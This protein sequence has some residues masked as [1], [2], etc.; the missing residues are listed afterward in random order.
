ML[1][2][3]IETS[4]P[5]GSIAVCRDEE[6]LAEVELEDAPRRHAQTLVSQIGDTFG[7]LSLKIADLDA[8]AVSIGPGSFTG[9]RVGVVCAKTLAYAIGCQLVAV[10]TLETIAANSPPD[11]VSVDVIADAQRGDL[12]VANYRRNANVAWDRDQ[13]PRI[14]RADEWFLALTERDVVSGPGLKVSQTAGTTVWRSL[15][16]SAW[17]P[18]ARKA[19]QIGARRTRL[20]LTADIATL[21]PFYVRRSAAEEK[22][23]RD[24][25][26]PAT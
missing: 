14:V 22:A 9:L 3:G 24:R 6:C 11:V 20:G 16:E 15:P 21:E 18:T 26:L 12:F 19:A 25:A 13:A 23:D 17:T 5:H 4:G 8:V 1:I 7:R 2:L 10:D